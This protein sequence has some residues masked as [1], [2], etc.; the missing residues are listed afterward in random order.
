[1]RTLA[2]FSLQTLAL[3]HPDS[4]LENPHPQGPAPSTRARL[5]SSGLVTLAG[6]LPLAATLP[7]YPTSRAS[8]VPGTEQESSGETP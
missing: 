5:T 8:P 3:M 4:H 2:L 1:M 7:V 6:C